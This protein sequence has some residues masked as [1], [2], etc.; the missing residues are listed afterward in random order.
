MTP[1]ASHVLA[2]VSRLTALAASPAPVVTST[3]R[4]AGRES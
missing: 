1:S 4:A 3:P 2:A